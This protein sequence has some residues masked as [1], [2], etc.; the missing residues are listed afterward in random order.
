LNFA[1][2]WDRGDFSTKDRRH[3]AK[4]LPINYFRRGS[5]LPVHPAYPQN[6]AD[7][8]ESGIT[9]TFS[10]KSASNWQLAN[11]MSGRE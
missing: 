3:S 7:E 2:A 9:S 1:I 5:G 8:A 10:M 6:S 11:L 4:K